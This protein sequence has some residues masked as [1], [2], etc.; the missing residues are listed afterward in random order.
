[1][2]IIH[3]H[4]TEQNGV[5]AQDKGISLGSSHLPISN[6]C[7]EGISSQKSVLHHVCRVSLRWTIPPSSP[8]FRNRCLLTGALREH[9]EGRGSSIFYH[10]FP[11]LHTKGA[12]WERQLWPL[13]SAALEGHI[14]LVPNMSLP[15]FT[16]LSM[17]ECIPISQAARILFSAIL[18]SLTLHLHMWG[19]GKFLFGPLLVT[20]P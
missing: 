7:K 11:F 16:S 5:S 15:I 3:S 9:T 8:G 20:F 10:L 14:H 1:M 2:L 12:P 6:R 18:N 4:Q 13:V 17:K 19:P